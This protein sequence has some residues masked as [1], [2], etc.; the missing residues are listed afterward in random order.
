MNSMTPAYR[1]IWHYDEATG[2]ADE[3]HYY[4]NTNIGLVLW[5]ADEVSY[6]NIEWKTPTAR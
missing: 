6:K 3:Y 5:E 1:T 2:K 4:T